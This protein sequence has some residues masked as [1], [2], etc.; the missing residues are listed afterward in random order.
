MTLELRFV[1]PDD[2]LIAQELALRFRVLRDPLGLGPDVCLERNP[3]LVY[4]RMTGW[5]QEG[6]LAAAAGHDINYIAVAGALGPIGRRGEAPVPP[7]NLVGDFGGGGMLLAFGMV[8]A[9]LEAQRSGRGQVVDAAM[10]DGAAA[11]MIASEAACERLIHH[12][13]ADTGM[14]GNLRMLTDELNLSNFIERHPDRWWRLLMGS[15]QPH[16]RHAPAQAGR[17]WSRRSALQGQMSRPFPSHPG[18]L[19]L[20]S[21]D[22][23]QRQRPPG[24]RGD[25]PMNQQDQHKRA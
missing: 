4:G 5:G 8:C 18:R 12:L 20:L 15:E 23:Y 1:D 25:N 24:F 9:L 10:V 19:L 22:K 13:E 7:L 11:L 2:P 3:R 14:Q 16:P 21:I 17:S 6:P